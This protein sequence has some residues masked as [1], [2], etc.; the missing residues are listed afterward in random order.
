MIDPLLEVIV[1]AREVQAG[2]VLVLEHFG[3]LHVVVNNAAVTNT[4]PL[5]Q[6]GRASCRER[7]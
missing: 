5:M 2:D 1:Q 3:A 6:I 7:V 4:T